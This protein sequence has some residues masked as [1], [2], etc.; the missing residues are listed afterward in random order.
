MNTS[1]AES[2]KRVQAPPALGE[3]QQYFQWVC[4]IFVSRGQKITKPPINP[5]V[6]E[7]PARKERMADTTDPATWTSYEQAVDRWINAKSYRGIGFVFTATDP[8]CGIDLDHCIDPTTHTIAPWA[9]H[10]LTLLSSYSEVSAQG[11]GIHIIVKAS[12]YETAR[13][14]AIASSDEVKHKKGDLE[15]YDRERYFTWSNKHIKGTPS[16]IEERQDQINELYFELFYIEE[17]DEEDKQQA[18]IQ[19]QPTS[20]ATLPDDDA[21]FTLAENARGHNGQLF[22]QLWRGDLTGYTKKD[23]NEI[24]YSRADLALCSIL[25]YWTQKD[26]GRIDRLFRQS[27]L[28]VPE[29]RKTKWDRPARGGETYGEGT[30]RIAIERCTKVYDPS[31]RPV[32]YNEYMA[33]LRKP[34][35]PQNASQDEEGARS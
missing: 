28:Y 16:T 20:Q 26:A 15:L 29:E 3:L 33:N 30:I 8:F 34:S 23:S 35:F 13:A 21:L 4:Y 31:W 10:I 17:E 11:T 1:I 12:L 14:L 32:P 25:A 7:F 27:G 2:Y 19:E 5:N 9:L 22:S 24:D 6:P 18:A